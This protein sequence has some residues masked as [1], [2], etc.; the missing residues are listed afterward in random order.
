MMP[1]THRIT[2][3]L[4]ADH[5]KARLYSSEGFSK[6]WALER[7]WF[8]ADARKADRELS[9]APPARN[10]KIGSGNRYSVEEPSPSDQAGEQFVTAL[11]QFLNEAARE[12]RFHQLVLAAPARALSTLRRYLRGEATE[13]YIAVWDKDLTNMPEAEL[14]SYCKDRLDRW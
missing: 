3:F 13:K 5:A 8:E 10:R 14:L 6:P 4:F 9:S 2:W 11:A 1:I 7:E 12:G